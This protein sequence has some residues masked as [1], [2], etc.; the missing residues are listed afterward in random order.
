[1]ES[2]ALGEVNL[3]LDD[4]DGRIATLQLILDEIPHMPQT[5]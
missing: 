1:M 3:C 4:R 5:P 2:V